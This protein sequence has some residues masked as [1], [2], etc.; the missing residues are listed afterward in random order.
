MSALPST[1]RVGALASV[2]IGAIFIP[3]LAGWA[4]PDRILELS[5]LVLAAMLASCLRVQEPATTDRAIMPPAF[6]IIFSSLMLFGPHVAMFVAV[7]ATLTPGFVSARIPRSR[8]LIDTAIV[9]VATQSAGLAH[10][11]VGD[12]RGEFLWPWLALSVAAAV[13]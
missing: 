13:V 5:G 8:M 10:R 6:V 9:I 7:A 1:S 2:F 12:L 3:R 4:Q 11:S